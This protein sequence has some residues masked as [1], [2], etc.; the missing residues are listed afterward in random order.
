MGN[1][2]NKPNVSVETKPAVLKQV[3]KKENVAVPMV[4]ASVSLTSTSSYPQAVV[5]AASKSESHPNANKEY[6]LDTFLDFVPDDGDG[7]G[8]GGADDEND[9]PSAT[10]AAAAT[11]EPGTVMGSKPYRCRHCEFTTNKKSS[12]YTHCEIRHGFKGTPD[13]LEIIGK[14][15]KFECKVRCFF[16]INH[17]GH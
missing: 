9:E 7:S 15:N 11:P 3:P 5:S 2:D 17:Y 12:V 8:G 10:A 14:E 6:S 13:D 16:V 4:S 1:S